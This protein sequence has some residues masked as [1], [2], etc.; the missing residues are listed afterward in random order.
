MRSRLMIGLVLSVLAIATLFPTGSTYAGGTSGPL[1]DGDVQGKIDKLLADYN[2]AVTLELQTGETSTFADPID[3]TVTILA[4]SSA[5]KINALWEKTIAQINELQARPASERAAA[6]ARIS[7]LDGG[8]ATYVQ[9]AG[10]PYNRTADLELYQTDNSV[11]TIDVVTNNIVEK[12]IRDDRAYSIQPKYTQDQL[13]QMAYDVVNAVDEVDLSGLKLQIGNKGGQTFF[14]RWE[15]STQALADGTHPF[16]QV[17]LSHAGDFLNYVNTFP[18]LDG[19]SS[20]AMPSAWSYFMTLVGSVISGPVADNEL[21]PLAS[22]NEVYANGGSYWQK[23]TGSMSTQSNAGYC[24]IA[25]WC[26]PTNFY[27]S[28]TCFGCVSVKGRWK[29]NT[30]PTV[31]PYAFVPSTHATT[32]MACYDN[33]Y[34]GGSTLHERCIN[35]NAYYN[36]WVTI[37]YSSLYNIKKIDLSNETDGSGSYQIAWDEVWLYAP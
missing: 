3:G 7:A 13:M 27:Y 4:G 9:K 10:S 21:R 15:D 32:L 30:N 16:V 33:Y 5:E 6:L 31:T 37:A 20:S 26:S 35:Q 34:N 17:G 11:Y 18:L 24:Y 12:Q 2:A 25:G 29:P 14:F 22:F 23:V 36:A 1:A 8:V 19:P 28:S